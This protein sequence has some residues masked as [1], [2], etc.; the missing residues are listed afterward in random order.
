MIINCELELG[1]YIIIIIIA[2]YCF[3]C[4]KTE[5]LY[6]ESRAKWLFTWEIDTYF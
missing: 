3:L 6:V 1:V 5:G 2:R 4:D